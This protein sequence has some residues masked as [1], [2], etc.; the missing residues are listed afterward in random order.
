MHPHAQLIHDFYTAFQKK[1]AEAMVACYHPA[2]TF[3]DPVFVN[4][5]GAEAGA[6]WR[7]LVERGKDLQ[8]TFR[9]VKADN[10]GGVAHWEASYTFSRT[11]RKVLNIIDAE[12]EFLDG[13][14]IEHHDNFDF[15]RWSRQALGLPGLLLGW[16]PILKHKVR[17]QSREALEGFIAKHQL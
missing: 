16:S 11:G 7:M 1:D 5:K 2:V 17:A 3:Y 15:W 8:L 14:I 4:L 10:D 9:D 13:K 6:M 12:F